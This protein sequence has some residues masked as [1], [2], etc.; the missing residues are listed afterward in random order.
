ML[1]AFNDFLHSTDLFIGQSHLL[2]GINVLAFLSGHDVSLSGV[3]ALRDHFLRCGFLDCGRCFL[4]DHPENKQGDRRD[5]AYP[6]ENK[7]K[8]M[9]V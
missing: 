1:R 3:T 4:L 5:E 6:N 8:F 9:G 2:A 7:P